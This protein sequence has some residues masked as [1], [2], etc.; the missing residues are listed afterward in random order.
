KKIKLENITYHDRYQFKQNIIT[1][2]DWIKRYK[3]TGINWFSFAWNG[4]ISFKHLLSYNLYFIDKIIHEDVAFG[5]NLFL[6]CN[7]IT[8]LPQKLY[9]YRIRENSLCDYNNGNNHTW[10]TPYMKNI[11]DQFQDI[12]QTKSYHRASSE[13]LTCIELLNFIENKI[14]N[15]YS[16]NILKNILNDRILCLWIILDYKKDPLK[17][18]N[19]IPRQLLYQ[20]IFYYKKTIEN[21]NR[22]LKDKTNELKNKNNHFLI[23]KDKEFFFT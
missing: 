20:K 12:Q 19:K 10:I 7:F 1:P 15:K 9:N 11:Y 18:L 4:M 2:L 23:L 8:Y 13:V 5:T 3:K 6:S 14:P 22:T 17:V 21:L 16:K